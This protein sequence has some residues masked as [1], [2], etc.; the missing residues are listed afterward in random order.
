MEAL[1]KLRKYRGPEA[2]DP[3]RRSS[4]WL[5][6]RKDRVRPSHEAVVFR[7]VR[8]WA[9][10]AVDQGR[11]D[12]ARAKQVSPHWLR[13]TFATRLLNTGAD[14]TYVQALLGHSSITTTMVYV[15]PDADEIRKKVNR[16][17]YS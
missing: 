5:F 3:S 13:H 1:K 15:T 2:K 9:T 12:P 7:A 4:L 16:L 14:V 17:S 11:F 6:P 8:R 10:T